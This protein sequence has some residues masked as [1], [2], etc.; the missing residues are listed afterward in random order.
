MFLMNHCLFTVR[1]RD[2]RIAGTR[3]HDAVEHELGRSPK[4]GGAERSAVGPAIFARGQR[5]AQP[6]DFSSPTAVG[7]LDFTHHNRRPSD[8]GSFRVTPA[9][10]SLPVPAAVNF[11]GPSSNNSAGPTA[12]VIRPPFVAGPRLPARQPS[13]EPSVQRVVESSSAVVE[14]VPGP[15]PSLPK[16]YGRKRGSNGARK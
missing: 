7:P 16:R 10:P 8:Y 12:F 5:S 15:R 13:V 9:S 11:A 3:E 2:A 4:R 6:Y 1:G 14:P